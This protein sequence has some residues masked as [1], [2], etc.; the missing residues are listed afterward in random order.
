VAVPGIVDQYIQT[1]EMLNRCQ[2]RSGCG[3]S[4]RHIKL[5][6]QDRRGVTVDQIIEAPDFPGSGE[7]TVT[8]SK[9]G[10]CDVAAQAAGAP[11]N[12]PDF[13]HGKSPEIE[14]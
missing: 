7:Q 13:R 10:F 4:V 2:N 9:H 11:G 12:Q 6:G 5:E 14:I 3:M 1:A 8:R